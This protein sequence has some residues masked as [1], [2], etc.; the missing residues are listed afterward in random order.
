MPTKARQASTPESVAIDLNEQNKIKLI[1][2][3]E[4]AQALS[5]A[6]DAADLGVDDITDSWDAGDDTASAEDFS[7]AQIEFKRATALYAAAQRSVQSIEKSIINT[8]TT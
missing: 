8:D 6:V 7:L 1:A 3:E 2:A 5:L 4:K